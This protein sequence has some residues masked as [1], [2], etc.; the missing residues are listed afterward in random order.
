M[1]ISVNLTCLAID[2]GGTKIAS[3]LVKNGEVFQ[4][5]QVETPQ[6]KTPEAITALL[7][8]VV[9]DYKGQFDCIGVASTGIINKGIL[10][11]LNPKNLGGLAEFPLHDCFAK[12][13]NKPIALL[14]DVQAAALAEYALLK[15]QSAV[16]NFTFITVSTGV[17][18]GIILNGELQTGNNG[19]TGHIGHIQTDPHGEVCGCGR[20]GCVEAIASGRAIE[21]AASL[22]EN[23]CTPKEVFVRFRKNDKN[24]TA[25]IQRSAKAI[26]NLIANLKIS[27]DM[28]LVAI[29]GSVGLAEGYLTE[30]QKALDEIPSIYHCKII[31]AQSGQDA[32]LLGAAI[33]AIKTV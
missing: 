29:G 20:I 22:W 13:T 14:N 27:L 28:E 18:G 4:R 17:G 19:V 15:D 9:N 11:A 10:T 32:G 16:S 2:I 7:T 31:N 5:Q 26:A 25:L 24:A 6:E 8:Q 33:W 1:N 12:L 21:H 23:P 3:A 30:I